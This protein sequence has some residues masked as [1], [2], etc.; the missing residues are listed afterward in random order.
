MFM[1]LGGAE[2]E[3]RHTHAHTA[4]SLGNVRNPRSDAFRWGYPLS[5]D[6]RQL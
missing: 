2:Q 4:L 1:V 6:I 5:S 3:F